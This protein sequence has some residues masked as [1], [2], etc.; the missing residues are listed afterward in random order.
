MSAKDEYSGA[1][2]LVLGAS[3]FIG[4]RVSRRL[5][6][7]GADVHLAVRNKAKALD[8]FNRYSVDGTAH[9]VDLSDTTQVDG[10]YQRVR[11][12]ITFNLAGYGIGPDE[13]DGHAAR[14][15]NADLPAFIC[16]AASRFGT[17][18]WAGQQIVHAGSA[19][20]YGDN[21]D[22]FAESGSTDPTSLYG[23]TKLEGTRALSAVAEELGVAAVTARIFNA[24]GP[25]ERAG[26]LL[27]SLIEAA[28]TGTEVRLTDGRQKRDFIYV[29]DI[30]EGLLRLG[31]V[32]DSQYHTFNLATGTFTTVKCFVEMAAQVL[33]LGARQ[34]KFGSISMAEQERGWNM[35]TEA[36]PVGRLRQT[37]NWTPSTSVATGIAKTI[38]F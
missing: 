10:L 14:R 27:P 38:K 17:G 11:P 18:N 35:D 4:R 29:D 2:V 7:R 32:R 24:Y 3:G 30:A 12:D 19:A 37:L 21:L 33:G 36:V 23:V 13:R 8:I 9:E 16:R 26:R 34:L 22:G 20:E 25:G 28:K 31:R 5:C 6:N 15:I 1:T